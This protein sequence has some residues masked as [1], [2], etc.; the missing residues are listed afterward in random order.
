MDGYV[1]IQRGVNK[2]GIADG[3][4]SYPTVNGATP[5]APVPTP[6]TPTGTGHYG[7]PPCK[8]DEYLRQVADGAVICSTGCDFSDAECPTYLPDGTWKASPVC[9]TLNHACGLSCG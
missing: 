5:P 7:A 9:D 1:L 6:P 3:P 4:P 2:C 8:E